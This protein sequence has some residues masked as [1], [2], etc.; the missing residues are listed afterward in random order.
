MSGE[1]Y[2]NGA[3]TNDP[4]LYDLASL[5][6]GRI[7][8][9]AR[10]YLGAYAS[11]EITPLLKWSNYLVTNLDDHSLYFSPSFLYSVRTNLDLTLGMQWF[12]G[13]EESEYGQFGDAYYAQLQWFF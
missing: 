12:Q 1:L 13:S 3:G 9:V 4:T 5:F 7:Q 2:Y 10:R 8:S 11:Y 6:A